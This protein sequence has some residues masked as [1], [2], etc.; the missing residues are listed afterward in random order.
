[1]GLYSD[2]ISSLQMCFVAGQSVPFEVFKSA[3]LCAWHWKWHGL[4]SKSE[5]GL[6]HENAIVSSNRTVLPFFFVIPWHEMLLMCFII[7]LLAWPHQI[8]SWILNPNTMNLQL[9][10]DPKPGISTSLWNNSMRK[11][12]CYWSKLNLEPKGF[13]LYFVPRQWCD[14]RWTPDPLHHC[15]NL[16]HWDRRTPCRIS[17]GTWMNDYCYYCC[18]W[19]TFPLRNWVPLSASIHWKV[20]LSLA[21]HY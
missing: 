7:T 11:M 19:D 8:S 14:S 9:W 18:Y 15:L 3:L 10:F 13:L 4:Q 6:V 1:M 2:H 21:S 16:R 20:E 17:L 12:S 5:P